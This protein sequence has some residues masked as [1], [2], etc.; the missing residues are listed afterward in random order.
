MNI[1]RLVVKHQKDVL[2]LNERKVK[3]LVV[4]EI[5]WITPWSVDIPNL[6]IDTET[7]ISSEKFG[8]ADVCIQKL[9]DN[10]YSVDMSGSRACVTIRNDPS[11][12]GFGKI[13]R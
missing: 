12:I 11:Y 4:G 1:A 9:S 13:I 8:T 6:T 3:D 2:E 7:F 10:W 5:V